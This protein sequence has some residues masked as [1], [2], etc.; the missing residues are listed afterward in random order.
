LKNL[1][2]QGNFCAYWL[3]T[4]NYILAYFWNAIWL[5]YQ[6]FIHACSEANVMI[7]FFCVFPSIFQLLVWSVR[8]D[9][10]LRPDVLDSINLYLTAC[11]PD[12]YV[13][14][15]HDNFLL[16]LPN[17][18]THAH[19]HTHTPFCMFYHVVLCVFS[20][21]LIPRFWHSLHIFSHS[22]VFPLNFLILLRFGSF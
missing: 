9:M 6:L 16:S 7:F 2:L 12:E 22:Q 5:V 1:Y 20:L 10:F 21:G 3:L 13:P 4:F 15:P 18:H 19:T 17:T 14:R 11:R 8:M